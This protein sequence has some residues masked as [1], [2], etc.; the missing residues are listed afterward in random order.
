MCTPTD[1]KVDIGN[2]QDQ[3]LTQEQQ[4]S[5]VMDQATMNDAFSPLYARLETME[6][7]VMSL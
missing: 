3:L 5:T 4:M 2:I 6:E 1:A 7:T